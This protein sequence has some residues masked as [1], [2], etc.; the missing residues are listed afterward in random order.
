VVLQVGELGRVLGLEL[1]VVVAVQE[2]VMELV[3]VVVELEQVL[4]VEQV[5]RQ[6]QVLVLGQAEL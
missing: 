6:E 5:A 2:E 1:P 3:V 4:V